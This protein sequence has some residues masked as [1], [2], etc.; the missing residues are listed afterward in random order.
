MRKRNN[1]IWCRLND[2]EYQQFHGNVLCT[3]LSQEAYLRKLVTGIQPKEA[4]PLEYNQ[5]IKSLSAIGKILNQIAIKLHSTGLF[6]DEM[7]QKNFSELLQTLIRINM[8]FE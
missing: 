6:D 3:G 7:F 4:P 2:Q 1:R 8:L 5:L